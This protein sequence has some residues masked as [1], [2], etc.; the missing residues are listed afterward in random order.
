MDHPSQPITAQ[1]VDLTS[2]Q[3]ALACLHEI[4]DTGDGRQ[5][6]TFMQ[7][8]INNLWISI[9]SAPNPIL[10][11]RYPTKLVGQ[12][13][14]CWIK[15][16]LTHNWVYKACRSHMRC[17][18]IVIYESYSVETTNDVLIKQVVL[19]LDPNWFGQMMPFMC[20]KY[21]RIHDINNYRKMRAFE[22]AYEAEAGELGP[23]GVYS[24]VLM[25]VLK[26]TSNGAIV[27]DWEAH[28]NSGMVDEWESNDEGE[29]EGISAADLEAGHDFYSLELG[30]LGYP[31]E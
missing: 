23:E 1:T 19:F 15:E 29:E 28:P 30:E 27:S 12:H 16:F 6:N 21:T 2:M 25:P 22:W 31:Q 14:L 7:A 26:V 17:T 5:A 20:A 10:S 24:A 13:L 18:D 8:I 9:G 11:A 4:T 3:S